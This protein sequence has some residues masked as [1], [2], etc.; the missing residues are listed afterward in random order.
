MTSW[1]FTRSDRGRSDPAGMPDGNH[2]NGQSTHAIVEMLAN[3]R[4]VDP[5]HIAQAGV[6]RPGRRP[7]AVLRE[8]GWR[9]RD[10]RQRP[11]AQRDDSLP[12][13]PRPLGSGARRLSDLN[14]ESLGQAGRRSE[15]RSSSTL[16][17]ATS[18]ASRIASSS[19]GA[20]RRFRNPLLRL[21]AASAV[22]WRPRETLPPVSRAP[23]LVS[24]RNDPN[25]IAEFQIDY[26][27]REPR[28]QDAARSVE[29][30]RIAI[31]GLRDPADD[32]IDLVAESR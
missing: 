24:D 25:E 7:T 3:S 32:E 9:A 8:A 6:D 1:T 20:T 15:A 12:T 13:R 23:T 11:L 19:G 21:S 4:K 26:A 31:R 28:K 27:E 29:V 18:S 2:L 14:S 17:R 30:R 5:A 16:T 10:L 22:R